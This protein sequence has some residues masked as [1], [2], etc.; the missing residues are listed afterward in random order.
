MCV[1]EMEFKGSASLHNDDINVLKN[2]HGGLDLRIERINQNIGR[3]YVVDQNGNAHQ[4]PLNAQ[5]CTVWGCSGAVRQ[6]CC[7]LVESG[8]IGS[9]APSPSF[10]F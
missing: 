10:N 4:L 9:P 2:V 7:W 8:G 6:D 1:A 3:V 5:V